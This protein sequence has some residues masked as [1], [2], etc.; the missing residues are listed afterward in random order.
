[1][2]TPLRRRLPLAL[3]QELLQLRRQWRDRREGLVFSH[4]HHPLELAAPPRAEI[5][6]PLMP[7]EWLLNK[8]ANLELAL[9]RLNGSRLGPA[10]T[11]SFWRA[12]GRPS[13]RRGYR[14]GRNLVNGQL[15]TQV[16]GG[17]CQLSGL[18]YH[19]GLLAGLEVVERHAHSVD[20]YGDG[21]RFTPLGADATVAWGSRDLRLGNPHGQELVLECL[22]TEGELIGRL[23]AADPL[24]LRELRFEREPATAAG[25]LRVRTWSDGQ[26]LV[27]NHYRPLQ[28]PSAPGSA[29]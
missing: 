24:P 12:L 25:H 5:R 11:W 3:R 8:R 20:V 15:V 9:E 16:G 4:G 14:R 10:T 13:A 28:S 23:R 7:G 18:L 29:P 21:E 27:T 17:L 6:Q 22:L 1:M 2:G 26:L 19:L